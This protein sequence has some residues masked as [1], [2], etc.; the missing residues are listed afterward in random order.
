VAGEDYNQ[1]NR[2][3]ANSSFRDVERSGF[4]FDSDEILYTG[5]IKSKLYPK[6]VVLPRQLSCKAGITKSQRRAVIVFAIGLA[7]AGLLAPVTLVM[8]GAVTLWTVFASLILWRFALLVVGWRCVALERAR[9]RIIE[10]V[11][12]LPVYSILVPVCD[13]AP[14]MRQLA[15]ALGRIDWPADLLDIQILLEAD[16]LQTISAAG[17]ARFPARTRFTIIP[18]GGPRTKPN[19][20]NY[21]LARARG[22]YV[23]IYDAEDR[24][25]PSQLREAYAAFACGTARLACVQA[26]LVASNMRAHWLSANWGLEYAVQFGFLLPALAGLKLPI[27]IG[28]TSNHFNISILRVSGGWDAWNVTEDADLGM[29]FARFGYDVGV[30]K[31]GTLE[32]APTAGRV[33]RAQRS[34]WIKGFIKTW[35]VLM[36]RPSRVLAEMGWRKFV[37][38]QLTLGG[39]VLAPLLHLPFALL[40]IGAVLSPGFSIGAMGMALIVFGLLVGLI[41]DVM[42]VKK[43]SWMVLAAIV[44]RPLYWPLHSIA[45]YIAL[46][47]LAVRPYFWAK[48]PH[49]PTDTEEEDAC[50]TG[51]S[52]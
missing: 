48:T 10:D 9:P 43:W 45:A 47:E 32:D 22:D 42:A 16:D 17:L 15:R 24:P 35:A 51:L 33:W 4:V 37:A 30:I 2:G 23:C 52:V 49:C 21:G 25:A 39:A 41:G 46:W 12:D 18:T 28:G 34:R 50:S 5:L 36:R 1:D 44:T 26:P 3:Y 20:L 40:L 19:A 8:G 14:V 7:G 29:R 6:D 38:A 31:A 27:L 13:E 11:A